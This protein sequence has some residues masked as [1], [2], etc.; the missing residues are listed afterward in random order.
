MVALLALWGQMVRRSVY[1]VLA[2]PGPRSQHHAKRRPRVILSVI[3]RRESLASLVKSVLSKRGQ[4]IGNRLL[5]DLVLILKVYL[6]VRRFLDHT[7]ALG[8]GPFSGGE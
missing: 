4:M 7:E 8:R 6:K 2:C 5:C 1:A 3:P